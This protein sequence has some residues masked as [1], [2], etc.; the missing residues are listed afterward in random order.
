[1]ESPGFFFSPGLSSFFSCSSF[2]SFHL[3]DKLKGVAYV[4]DLVNP[5]TPT[6]LCSCLPFWLRNHVPYLKTFPQ[7]KLVHSH[8]FF[9]LTFSVANFTRGC[10]FEFFRLITI[11][12]FL[13]FLQAPQ[14]SMLTDHQE[15][16]LVTGLGAWEKEWTA[17]PRASPPCQR[18]FPGSVSTASA[19][20]SG[21]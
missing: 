3:Q 1:M 11:L 9:S 2:Y 18:M 6:M 10:L 14:A 15:L 20:L 16:T 19:M 4:R 12:I 5:A 8:Q 13:L 7:F 17:I 21:L